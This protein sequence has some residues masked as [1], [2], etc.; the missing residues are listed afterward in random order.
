MAEVGWVHQSVPERLKR[1]AAAGLE[2]LSKVYDPDAIKFAATG[3]GDMGAIGGYGEERELERHDPLKHELDKQL[4]NY[5]GPKDMWGSDHYSK[6]RA[7][8]HKYLDE[9]DSEDWQFSDYHDKHGGNLEDFEQWEHEHLENLPDNDHLYDTMQE[10]IR[11]KYGGGH[12]SEVDLAY[13]VAPMAADMALGQWMTPLGYLKHRNM[14]KAGQSVDEF[15]K[16]ISKYMPKRSKMKPRAKKRLQNIKD[17]K[18]KQDKAAEKRALD[19][20]WHDRK[21]I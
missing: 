19:A 18:F 4:V 13:E 1:Q 6:E 7:D 17:R 11:D 12:A 15:G 2:G 5:R 16:V 8:F 10:E 21:G 14:L 9:N 20:R 3:K